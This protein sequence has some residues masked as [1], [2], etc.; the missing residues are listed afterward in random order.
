MVPP[1]FC[2]RDLRLASPSGST[3]SSSFVSVVGLI[4]R[5]ECI[6]MWQ[7][8]VPHSKSSSL[9]RARLLGPC[10]KFVMSTF[11]KRASS[12]RIG[13]RPFLIMTSLPHST[14]S[15]AWF[16]RVSLISTVCLLPT[17]SRVFS[18]GIAYWKE[19]H[20]SVCMS[21]NQQQVLFCR[22]SRFCRKVFL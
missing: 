11:R 16:G 8:S 2:I 15:G 5:R 22:S 7:G 14:N 6:T 21:P 9:A 1:T 4:F 12:T 20:S 19:I 17:E 3:S 10:E 13:G 18:I